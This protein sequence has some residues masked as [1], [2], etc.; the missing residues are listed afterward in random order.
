MMS[1]RKSAK[2]DYRPLFCK[3]LARQWKREFPLT[4]LKMVEL[5]FNQERIRAYQPN[6]AP[7]KRRLWYYTP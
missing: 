1:M 3:Y 7:E 2:K 4:P 5:Y 6:T